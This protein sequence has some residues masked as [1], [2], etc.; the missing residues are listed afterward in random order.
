MRVSLDLRALEL[1]LC[2][3]PVG[4]TD[5]AVRQLLLSG[6]HVAFL[7]FRGAR[8]RGVLAPPGGGH[9][10]LRLLQYRVL[11]HRDARLALARDVVARKIASQLDGA[12]HFQRHGGLPGEWLDALKQHR[13]AANTAA[14]HA[15]LMGIEG[16]ATNL[17]FRILG[18]RFRSPWSFSGRNRRPPRDPVNALLS[19][20]YTLLT[21]RLAARC[22]AVGLEIGL[23]ALHEPRPGRPALV[24]DLVEPLRVRV[25]DRWVLSICHRG[26][27]QPG[28]FQR[29]GQG[30]VILTDDAFSRVLGQW[31]AEWSRAQH[32]RRIENE[33]T[34]FMQLLRHLDRK[35]N[36]G[37]TTATGS[38]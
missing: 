28:D 7:S 4:V 16:A 33:I 18:A 35:F 22:Q 12:R 8:F 1:V 17:W 21:S 6:V 11:H 24:C 29:A 38:E 14:D 9:T 32:G 27:V 3:G 19:L 37:A 10:G 23:G 13:Q 26:V 5:D 20:G 25:V 34:R 30:G 36:L 15:A 2:Y 31:E